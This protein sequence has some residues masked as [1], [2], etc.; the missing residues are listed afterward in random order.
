[1]RDCSFPRRAVLHAVPEIRICKKNTEFLM[2]EYDGLRILAVVTEE[3]HSLRYEAISFYW[4]ICSYNP[5][6]CIL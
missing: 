4:T 6:H 5:E 3:L 2:F 1:M